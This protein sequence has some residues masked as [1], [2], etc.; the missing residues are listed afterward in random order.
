MTNRTWHL[1]QYNEARAIDGAD[2]EAMRGFYARIQEINALAESSPGFVWRPGNESTPVEQAPD[3]PYMLLNISVWTSIETLK[4]FTYRSAHVELFHD[5]QWWF[6]VPKGPAHVLW[7]VRAGERPSSVDGMAR[8][9]R[10][11]KDGPSTEGFT[12]A[13]PFPAP[14]D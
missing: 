3:D 10:L 7:W 4:D 5:R 2:G 14:A 9:Q 8:L 13:H 11:R 12:F 1:A 6:E